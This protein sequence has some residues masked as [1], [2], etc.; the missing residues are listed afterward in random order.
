MLREREKTVK[1]DQRHEREKVCCASGRKVKSFG[2]KKVGG[3][4]P[5]RN[6]GDKREK[7]RHGL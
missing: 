7:E 6:L 4:R 5:R 3:E 2:K 1:F